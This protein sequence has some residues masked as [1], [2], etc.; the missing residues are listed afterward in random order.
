MARTPKDD[1]E[2]PKKPKRLA[3]LRETYRMAKRSD[4]WIGW[5]SIGSGLLVWAA[6]IGLG[7]LVFSPWVTGILGFSMGLLVAAFIF[8]RRAERAAYGQIEGQPGAAAA[9]LNS[10]RRGWTVTPA[11]AVTR[12]QDVVHR[13]VGRP[14][15]VLV[16][17]GVPSRVANLLANEKRRHSRVAPD[18]P[19]YDIIVGEGENQVTL[20]A[21]TKHLTKLPRAIRP[22]DVTDI[23]YRIK[24]LGNNPLPMPKGPL[25]KTTRMPKT[26]RFQ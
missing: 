13:A 14:G 26:G 6:F 24:A 12:Q 4:R 19:V 21:L 18:A 22:S 20:R 11:I 3:Q 10:L 9:V 1:V 15:I 23:N 5:I 17:E 25:P 16:G 2:K 8:G 7:F